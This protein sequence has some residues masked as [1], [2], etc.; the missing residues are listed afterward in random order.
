M[1]FCLRGQASGSGALN[2]HL[3]H[4]EGASNSPL[5]A[6]HI[7]ASEVQLFLIQLPTYV[8]RRVA[9]N[10]PRAPVTHTQSQA[11]FLA[12]WFQ[13]DLILAAVAI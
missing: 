4:M 1:C 6:S 13:L 12:P 3:N 11:E 2:L 10:G 8:P 9:G 7:A 5:L